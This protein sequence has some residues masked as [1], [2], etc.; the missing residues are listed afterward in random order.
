MPTERS[1]KEPGDRW[2]QRAFRA[3]GFLLLTAGLLFVLAL[4][5]HR[6]RVRRA[7]HLLSA[8]EGLRPGESRMSDVQRVVNQ[9]RSDLVPNETQCHSADCNFTFQ[10]RSALWSFLSPREWPEPYD[11]YGTE[12]WALGRLSMRSFIVTMGVKVADDVLKSSYASVV[13]EGDCQKWL[14]GTWRHIPELPAFS[15][16][17]LPLTFAPDDHLVITSSDFH[18]G[19]QA[20]EALDAI[21]IPGAS[22]AEKAAAFGINM[23]CLTS[24]SGC[25]SLSDLMPAAVQLQKSRGRWPLVSTSQTCPNHPTPD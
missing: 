20:G 11:S 10:I 6:Y 16:T 1:K 25:F 13:V 15:K 24:I 2:F 19:P 17:K 12:R 23:T 14:H 21:V 4:A 5:N 18:M 7:S 8:M 3:A 9:Y 22:S